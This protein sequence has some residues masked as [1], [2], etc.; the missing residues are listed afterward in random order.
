MAKG[1]IR[2]RFPSD[3][4]L[5]QLLTEAMEGVGEDAEIIF[6]AHALHKTGR[7]ARGVKSRTVGGEVLVTVEAKNPLSGF[8]YVAVTRFGHRKARIEPTARNRA[9][10]VATGRAR[11]RGREAMLRF[12]IGGR[13]MYR[14]SVR[15]FHPATDWAATAMPEVNQAAERSLGTLGRKIVLRRA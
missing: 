7:M 4:E 13:V 5:D 3:A 14:R 8:D 1:L 15:G 11:K 2:S 6:A 9:T 10:V 12:V